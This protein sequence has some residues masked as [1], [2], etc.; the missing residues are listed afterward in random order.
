MTS[1]RRRFAALALG[2]TL[3]VSG[4]SCSKDNSPTLSAD[5]TQFESTTTTTGTPTTTALSIGNLDTIVKPKAEG[6]L[7]VYTTPDDAAAPAQ[8]LANPWLYNNEPNA[9]VPRVLLA[10]DAKPGWIEVYLPQRPNGSTGWVK[11]ADVTTEPMDYRIEVRMGE[12][13]LKAFKGDQVVL[14]TKIAVGTSD[15]PTPGGVYFTS[16][17]IQPPN[18]NG[19]YGPY[20]WGLS[21]YSE[22]LSSFNG[23]DGQLGIHGTNKPQLLGTNVSHGCIRVANADITKMVNEL[24]R[25]QPLGIPVQVFA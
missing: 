8:Q 4:V 19:D 10:K 20:A 12:F 24:F 7:A 1:A 16:V 22:T 21:G 2:A 18:P 11:Q 3:L 5:T 17:L 14:D 15:N 6:Q 25:D 9:K 23:G 13:N